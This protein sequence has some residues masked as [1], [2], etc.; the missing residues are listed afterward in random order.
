MPFSGKLYFFFFISLLFHRHGFCQVSR[1]IHITAL[2]HSHIIAEK[3]ERDD[4]QGIGKERIRLGNVNDIIRC[5]FNFPV[6]F[7]GH[8]KHKCA[9]RFYL[10][11]I[12]D[13]F[14]V[15]RGLR[16]YRRH[17]RSFLYQ[18]YCAMLQF[19]RRIGLRVDIGNFLQL[20]RAFHGNGI[21]NSP[22]DK[23]NILCRN[24]PVGKSLNPVFIIQKKFYLIGQTAQIFQHTLKFSFRYRVSHPGQL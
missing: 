23:E 19:S 11:H 6:S 15:Q 14:L 7:T 5:L 22:A 3:L 13:G 16:G 21:V 9:S 8:G 4:R 24:I 20:Q 12:A 17:K 1:L 18:G 10:Y 2:P